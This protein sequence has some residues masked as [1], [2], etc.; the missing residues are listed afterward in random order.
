MQVDLRARFKLNVKKG[1][2]KLR[3]K[4]VKIP[5]SHQLRASFKI[6]KTLNDILYT[7]VRIKLNKKKIFCASANKKL[8][9]REY[10]SVTLFIDRPPVFH[11]IQHSWSI[12]GS[13]GGIQIYRKEESSRARNAPRVIEKIAPGKKFYREKGGFSAM[14]RAV[15]EERNRE[16]RL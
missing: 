11:K 15:A 4:S 2:K 6:P 5:F 9:I 10:E 13:I 14:S 1:K 12:P 16:A 3:D 7:C 8:Q